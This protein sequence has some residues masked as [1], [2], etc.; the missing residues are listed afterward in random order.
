M[1]RTAKIIFLAGCIALSS[2][3]AGV[4]AP[5]RQDSC[6]AIIKEAIRAV[7]DLKVGDTRAK[8][9]HNFREDGGISWWNESSQHSRYLYKKCTFIKIDVEYA[10]RKG[11]TPGKPS[12]DDTVTSISK[13][14]LEYPFYD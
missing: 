8:I 3:T 14:Y 10:L 6:E 7:D 13:P 11:S 1:I 9:E 5:A 12:P 4:C 2:I